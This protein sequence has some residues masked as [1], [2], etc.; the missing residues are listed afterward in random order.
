M[1]KHNLSSQELADLLVG[2][3]V[4]IKDG[5]VEVIL[6]IHPLDLP[7]KASH[8]NWEARKKVTKY[9]KRLLKQERF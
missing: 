2:R 6:A 8:E 1:V 4:K 3:E 9:I 7:Y 5:E